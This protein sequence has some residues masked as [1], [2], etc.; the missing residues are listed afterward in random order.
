M[1]GELHHPKGVDHCCH[2]AEPGSRGEGGADLICAQENEKLADEVAE[3]RK[4]DQGH[5]EDHGNGPRPRHLFP[6]SAHPGDLSGMHP[7]LKGADED[8]ERAR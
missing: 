5:G 3:P 8:E 6:Q 2:E 1:E 4:A 7:V